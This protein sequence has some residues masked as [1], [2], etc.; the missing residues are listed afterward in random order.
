MKVMSKRPGDMWAGKLAAV[1]V[2]IG[3]LLA[4]FIVPVAAQG[5]SST[6]LVGRAHWL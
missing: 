4:V 3:L 6:L 1:L 5:G 2:G